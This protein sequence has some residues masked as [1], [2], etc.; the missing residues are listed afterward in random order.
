MRVENDR[1]YNEM[2]KTKRERQQQK[3]KTGRLNKRRR[4]E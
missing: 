1:I 3:Y 4:G 2:H